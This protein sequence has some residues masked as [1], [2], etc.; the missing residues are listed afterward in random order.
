VLCY[1]VIHATGPHAHGCAKEMAGEDAA[2]DTLR[3]LSPQTGVRENTP[4]T[5]LWHTMEDAAVPAA[6][7]F[8]FAGALAEKGVPYEA[9]VY[10]GAPHGAGLETPFAWDAA[11]LRW[12]DACVLKPA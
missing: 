5:F 3:F 10:Q 12:L 7:T 8:A 2:E 1:P 4:P 6:N 9:H 11:L